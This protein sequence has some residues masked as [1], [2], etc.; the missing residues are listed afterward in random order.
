M[1]GELNVS[2]SI[3]A[4]K[5]PTLVNDTVAYGVPQD[6]AGVYKEETVQ[7]FTVTPSAFRLGSITNVGYVV[8]K[9]T[10]ASNNLLVSNGSGG[11]PVVS[12]P[13]G[14]VALFP[15]A[16]NT[17]FGAASTATVVAH[18]TIYEA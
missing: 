11:A 3:S 1:A 15:S 5:A 2:V 10:G 13:P 6:M 12:I 17:L 8:I 7:P 18:I 4:S 14:G 9:N 16:S